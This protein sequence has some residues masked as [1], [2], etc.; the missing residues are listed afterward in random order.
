MLVVPAY[1]PPI[2]YFKKIVDEKE[3]ELF[4]DLNYQKQ[5]YRNRCM[6]YGANDRLRLTIPIKHLNNR[7]KDKEVN[8]YN[9]FNWQKNH[10]KSLESAYRSSPFF[11][12]YEDDIR[13]FYTKKYKLLY[14]LNIDLINFVVDCIGLKIQIK[15]VDSNNQKINIDEILNPKNKVKKI[16]PYRQVFDNKNGFQSDLSIIDLLF[17]LG[18]ES[19]D[20]IKS[21]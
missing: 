4:G 13:P 11:E 17:N 1:L 19:L 16:K 21:L 18:P 20:Y 6:I 8:I 14:N 2:S 7:R 10:W 9:G 3:L 15:E 12:Y 5:T